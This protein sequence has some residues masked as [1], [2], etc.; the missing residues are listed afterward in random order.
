MYVNSETI[1]IHVSEGSL[2]VFERLDTPQNEPAFFWVTNKYPE[3]FGP[4]DSISDAM[5]HAAFI[6]KLDAKRGKEMPPFV[7]SGKKAPEAPPILT[8]TDD[9]D[10]VIYVDFFNKRRISK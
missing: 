3:A 8:T 7:D 10:N 1:K 9:F 5:S 4:F 2:T 6:F